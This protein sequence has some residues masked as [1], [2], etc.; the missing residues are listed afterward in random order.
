MCS[1][2]SKDALE[3]MEK[4]KS[5]GHQDLRPEMFTPILYLTVKLHYQINEEF[6]RAVLFSPNIV[7]LITVFLRLQLYRTLSHAFL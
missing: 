6:L 5:E 3:W 1:R 7:S 4:M 2:K